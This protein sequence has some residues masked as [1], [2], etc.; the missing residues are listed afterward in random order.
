MQRFIFEVPQQDTIIDKAEPEQ[1][2]FLDLTGR[3]ALWSQGFYGQG[4]VV[5]VVD[6]GVNQHPEFEDRLLKG[7]NFTRDYNSDPNRYDDDSGH[8][9]HVAGSIAGV[10]AGVAPK[11]EILPIKVLGGGGYGTWEDI[12]EGLEY[13]NTWRHPKTGQKVSAVSMSL[14]A[15][16]KGISAAQIRRL[17]IAIQNLVQNDIPVFCSMG[18]TG[19]DSIR[20]PASF[21][22]VIAVGAVDIEHERA[23]FTTTG[24]HVDICEMGV[25]V[26]SANYK[27]GYVYMSGTSM[28]TPI[29][30]GLAML[31]ANKYRETFEKRIPEPFLY[32]LIKMNTKD[33]GIKGVDKVHGAGFFTLQP[34]EFKL[35]TMHG[36]KTIVLNGEPVE[37]E[38]PAEIVNGRFNLPLRYLA[39]PSGA[40]VMWDPEEKSATVRY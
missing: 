8:G 2:Q 26:L 18:N 16:D 21:D 17:K 15:D 32:E 5:A 31:L 3:R 33:L 22:E 30:A 25:H 11:A 29:S 23:Y 27:G 1:F 10:L 35:W 36:E 9:T 20:Y 14:S 34:L 28:S 40:Y 38:R 24:D 7:R 39:D 12:S 6:S 13:I 37:M 4:E 19:G